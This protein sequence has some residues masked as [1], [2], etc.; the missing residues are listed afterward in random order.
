MGILIILLEP[1]VSKL[2]AGNV[3]SCIPRSDLVVAFTKYGQLVMRK[4]SVLVRSL[5]SNI[6]EWD[7]GTEAA[8]EAITVGCGGA[9]K[10]GSRQ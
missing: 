7:V 6:V 1:G 2:T 4:N 9:S 5:G 3:S 10:R 8:A